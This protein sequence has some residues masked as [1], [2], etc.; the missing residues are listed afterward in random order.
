MSEPQ[1][2]PINT[3]HVRQQFDRRAPLDAQQFLY[4]EIALRMLSRL[5]YIRYRPT[6]ILDAGCGAG[7]AIDTLQDQYPEM[8]YTGLDH[9][10]IMLDV[11]RPRH[12]NHHSILHRLLNKPSLP[13]TFDKTHLDKRTISPN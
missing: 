1:F 12:T 5:D 4:G 6:R 2:L 8:Q 13:Y 9:S 7:H 11:A 3:K 10:P